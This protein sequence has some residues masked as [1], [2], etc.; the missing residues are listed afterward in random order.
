MRHRNVRGK[1]LYT[2]TKEGMKGQ[3]RGR[4]WFNFSHHADGSVIMSAQCE[5]AE[6]DPTVL[7]NIT[8][9]IGPDMVPQNLLV[10]L[11]LGDEFLGSGWMRNDH[12]NGQIT[13]ESYGPTIGR[14]SET[15]DADGDFDGFGT[16]PIVSDGFLTRI[17]DLSKG[18]HKR[19]LRVFLPSP[20]HRGATPPQISEV[21]ITLEYVGREEK[22]CA[23]G[24]FACRHLRFIDDSDEGMGGTSHPV[25]DMWVTDDDDSILVYGAID[26]YMQNRYE[27]VELDR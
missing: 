15:C 6:P 4:E 16:H 22:S 14:N 21:F 24:T 5:I 20:D 17:M 2:S 7:R 10:H 23:A 1:I 25:Y 26:G 9:H 3:E 13:C 27:L 19:K 11:T 12:E 8:Y 18:P